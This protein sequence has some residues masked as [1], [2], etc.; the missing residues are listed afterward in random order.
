V[1]ADSTGPRRRQRSG[2]VGRHRPKI[3]RP[4]PF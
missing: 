3:R 4:A 2:S 1:Q